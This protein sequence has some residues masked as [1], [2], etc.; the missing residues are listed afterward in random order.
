VGYIVFARLG[1]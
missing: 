1:K